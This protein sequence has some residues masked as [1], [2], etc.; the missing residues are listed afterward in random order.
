MRNVFVSQQSSLSVCIR[1]IADA[2]FTD[3]D[4]LTKS[5]ALYLEKPEGFQ[6]GTCKYATATNATHGKCAIVSGAIHLREGCCA[7]WDADPKQLHMYR[8]S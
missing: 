7:M 3:D 1:D 5:A 4:P 2:A 8:E 6:C